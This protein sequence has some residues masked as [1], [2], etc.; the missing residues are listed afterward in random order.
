VKENKNFENRVLFLI[1]YDLSK[2]SKEN[3]Q[4]Q[5]VIG[6]PSYG[7]TDTGT[8]KNTDN[9]SYEEKLKDWESTYK[10]FEMPY[11][12]II[13]GDSRSIKIPINK[14]RYRLT[15]DVQLLDWFQ[16][17]GVK[18]TES[19]FETGQLNDFVTPDGI[20][21]ATFVQFSNGVAKF[22]GYCK[23][24][25]KSFTSGDCYD[26]KK[27]VKDKPEPTNWHAV[28]DTIEIVSFV[29][30]FFTGP[31]GAIVLTSISVGAG[32]TNSYLYFQEGK[33]FTGTMYLL[34][35][36]VGTAPLF[37]A[38][39]KVVQKYTSK[40]IGEA[41]KLFEEG[42]ELTSKQQQIVKE[43][44]DELIKNG[45]KLEVLLAKGLGKEMLNKVLTKYGPKALVM[46]AMMFGVG[47]IV[48]LG[49][50]YTLGEIWMALDAKSEQEIKE[51]SPARKL[52]RAIW[53]EGKENEQLISEIIQ[54]VQRATE[55]HAEE[56]P[57]NFVQKDLFVYDAEQ[58][59]NYKDSV[60]NKVKEKY[61][62]P[63]FKRITPT[64]KQVLNGEIDKITKKPYILQVGDTGDAIIKIKDNLSKIGYDSEFKSDKT[65]I[66][67]DN[68]VFVIF[69]FQDK[70]KINVDRIGEIIDT[71][72]LKFLEQK[73][74][75]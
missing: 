59:K 21:W 38:G 20:W 2:T 7:T 10:E 24:E 40:E 50:E 43:T 3:I 33:N 63:N 73:L 44:I 60:I 30:A 1:N 62:N 47:T 17:E 35:S 26:P 6:A 48:V 9:R 5:S 70:N 72:T 16:K 66:Y 22:Y 42:A 65:N 28:L 71:E 29:A 8:A 56:N 58:N 18:K 34:F 31:L 19:H 61:G 68:L 74:K 11:D 13:Y 12:S 54:E 55:K 69:D 36:I 39:M 15:R 75:N 4:E 51:N 14:G 49:F 67:N 45:A 23:R 37:K 25:T 57:K 41:I 32:L 53:D 52:W 46:Q 27:Y 64:Y